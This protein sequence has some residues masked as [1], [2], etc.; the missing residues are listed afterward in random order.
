MKTEAEKAFEEYLAWR[1]IEPRFDR[2]LAESSSVGAF[3]LDVEGSEV[4]VLVDAWDPFLAKATVR[5]VV[6]FHAH[7]SVHLPI[8]R[9]ALILVNRGDVVSH[10]EALSTS[11]LDGSDLMASIEIAGCGV[12][13]LGGGAPGRLVLHCR[14]S[15]PD[16][17]PCDDTV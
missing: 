5:D 8:E 9:C 11:G 13:E 16:G 10:E 1:G 6:V 15:L 7:A 2:L 17:F 4:A 14:R 12:L 3:F